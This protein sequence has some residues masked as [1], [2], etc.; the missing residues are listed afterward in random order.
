[1]KTLIE[2]E[3]NSTDFTRLR[4]IVAGSAGC[5]KSYLIGILKKL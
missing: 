2:F 3:N 4:L 5:G 1:M